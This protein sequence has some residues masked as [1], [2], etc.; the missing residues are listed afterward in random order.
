M[1]QCNLSLVFVRSSWPAGC[2]HGHPLAPTK[3][4]TQIPSAHNR[5]GCHSP[6]KDW[7][8]ECSHFLISLGSRYVPGT[9]ERGT[10]TLFAQFSTSPQWN[11]LILSHVQRENHVPLVYTKVTKTEWDHWEEKSQPSRTQVMW[12]KVDPEKKIFKSR[13]PMVPLWEGGKLTFK[14]A[15]E[16]NTSS[17]VSLCPPP[18]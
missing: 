17:N 13:R 14:K 7:V 10:G 5:K 18:S 1:S 9:K 12:D 11:L 3:C 2:K 15:E 6:L 8:Y 16:E 4:N